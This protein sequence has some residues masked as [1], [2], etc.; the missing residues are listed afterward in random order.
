MN[1]HNLTLALGGCV[2]LGLSG[3][4]RAAESSP[5][6]FSA[7]VALTS[8]YVWRGVSQTDSDPAIQ[9]G[10]DYEHAS[11]FS[12]GIWGSNVDF[13][14]DDDSDLELDYYGGFSWQVNEVGFNVGAIYYDYPG[15]SDNDFWEVNA[16]IGYSY[17]SAKVSYTDEFGEGGEEAVYYEAGADFELPVAGGVGL[18]LHVGYYDIDPADGEDY[19]DWKIALSKSIGGFDFELAYTDTD[20]DGSDDPDDLAD[21]R[22]IFTLSRSF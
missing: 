15:E 6:S 4:V 17:F 7:N 12:L 18:G 1:V 10:F 21:G 2:L 11:G 8:D 22:V 3:M 14:D 20:I 5:H 9:G 19:T 13:G 16:G